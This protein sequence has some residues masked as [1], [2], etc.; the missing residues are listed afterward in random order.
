MIKQSKN[1]EKVME[2]SKMNEKLQASLDDPQFSDLLEESQQYFDDAASFFHWDPDDGETTCILVNVSHDKTMDKKLKKE[3][4]VVRA[5]VEIQDGDDAGKTFDLSG[6]WGWTLRNFTGLKTLAS[7]LAGDP[8]DKFVEAID[9]LYDNQGSG[10]LVSTSRQPRDG[11]GEPYVNHRVRQRI[12]V[13]TAP[14]E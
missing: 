7:L 12:E 13:A 1:Q 8:V 2:K 9:I 10:L 11:G 4:V 14:A 3:V 6:P 5:V